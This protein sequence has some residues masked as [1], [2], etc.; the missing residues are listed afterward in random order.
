LQLRIEIELRHGRGGE[1]NVALN[2][3]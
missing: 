2:A 1:G 3:E